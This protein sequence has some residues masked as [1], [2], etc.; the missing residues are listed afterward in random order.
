MATGIIEE[1]KSF[2]PFLILVSLICWLVFI[3]GLDSG[4]VSDDL[5]GFTNNEMVKSFQGLFTLQGFNLQ[6]ILYSITYNLF[7][8]KPFPLHF[9]F[10]LF[11]NINVILVFF[12]VLK[13]SKNKTL[14]YI[15]SALF[16][17]HP[18]NTEALF[19]ISA[20][21]YV[22]NGTALLTATMLYL[23]FRENKKIPYLVISLLIFTLALF[24]IRH[25]WGLILP[26]LILN[27]EF[28][29]IKEEEKR[30]YP[31]FYFLIGAA[32]I[33][34]YY[35]SS[36]STRIN[37]MENQIIG[38][39]TNPSYLTRIAYTTVSAA[40][41]LSFPKQLSLYHEG[42]TVN[43]GIIMVG[44]LILLASVFSII[45]LMFKKR[46]IFAFF[47]AAFYISILPT[48][49]PI[50]VAW[51]IADRY[52]YLSSMVFAV[53]LGIIFLKI[54]EKY[55]AK[56]LLPFLVIFVLGIYGYK[57]M[58]RSRDWQNRKTLWEA[59]ARTNPNSAR[60]YNN[61]GD[62]YS[63]EGNLQKSIQSFQK[64]IELDPNYAEAMYNLGRTYI[65]AGEQEKGQQLIDKAL[66]I[67]PTMLE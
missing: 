51:F 10:L 58:L 61:L 34:V 7:G 60:V 59:T 13:V 45:Y 32:F 24:I 44:H 14:G 11:H 23:H 35:L 33:G 30:Y 26:F 22:L 55:K 47:I 56:R 21:H 64:A 18:V 19:W 63:I 31:I 67:K 9:L 42:E 16:M 43:I 40:R 57:V 36:I 4:F 28:F 65:K 8:L 6:H 20:G 54:T 1:V 38:G 62:V 50:Q 41:L 3:P 15:S 27:I 12:L 39:E 2:A 48:Y 52:L 46:K 25:A 29:L 17:L 49:S 37:F 53:S 5:P 66:Q